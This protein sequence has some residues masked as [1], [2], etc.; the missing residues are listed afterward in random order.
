MKPSFLHPLPL[1]SGILL[2]GLAYAPA[3]SAAPASPTPKPP[4]HKPEQSALNRPKADARAQ[5][6]IDDAVDKLREAARKFEAGE[7]QMKRID[8][9]ELQDIKNNPDKTID[10]L[11]DKLD[12]AKL[13]EIKDKA[14]EFSESEKGKKLLEDLKKKGAET[15]KPKASPAAPAGKFVPP[16]FDGVPAPQ[17]AKA[18]P[19]GLKPRKRTQSAT[20]DKIIGPPTSDPANPDRPISPDDPRG[21]TYVL[22]GNAQVKTPSMVLEAERITGVM[23][24]GGELP[25]S[26]SPKSKEKTKSI[27][28]V[29][30]GAGAAPGAKPE[31]EPF[32][33]LMAEGRVNLV[34]MDKGDITTGKGGSLI[35][36]KKSGRAVLTDW[37]QV[38]QGKTL[39]VA[40]K[41]DA[42]I[43]IVPKGQPFSEGCRI[44]TLEDNKPPATAPKTADATPKSPAAPPKA[45]RVP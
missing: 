2:L 33:S 11:K 7:K 34:K 9:Q 8:N 32:D 16:T 6:D 30:A 36:D 37:P 5:K 19:S 35:Y 1:W 28:P 12:P 22:D 27:D 26:K 38:Q 13:Q 3:Q 10:A 42:T 20:A 31:E 45:T 40:T 15:I 44:E 4:V 43:T 18:S 39:W 23:S 17:A 14:K 29:Q 24:K 21:R 41:K 25:G